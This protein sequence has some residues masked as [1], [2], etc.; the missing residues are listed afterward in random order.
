MNIDTIIENYDPSLKRYKDGN[1]IT[2]ELEIRKVMNKNNYDAWISKLNKISRKVNK[3]VKSEQHYKITYY[4]DNKT[5]KLTFKNGKIQYIRKTVKK[6]LNKNTKKYDYLSVNKFHAKLSLSNEELMK[7]LPTSAGEVKHTV[8]RKRITYQFPFYKIDLDCD[9]NSKYSCEIELKNIK[10]STV[11]IS[12]KTVKIILQHIIH[13]LA[14]PRPVAQK[15]VTLELGYIPFLQDHIVLPKKDGVT[16]FILVDR[17]GMYI[18]NQ[19]MN[20]YVYL[21]E[22]KEIDNKILL[23]YEHRVFI[24]EYIES[25]N[26]YYIFDTYQQ[27]TKNKS[28]SYKERLAIIKDFCKLSNLF[29]I[30]DYFMKGSLRER[31]VNG[32][33]YIN[34]NH[35]N[36]LDYDGLI[37]Q[38]IHESYNTKTI[39]KW[40]PSQLNT[41]DLLY[42]GG[43]LYSRNKTGLELVYDPQEKKHSTFI[44]SFTIINKKVLID[45]KIVEMHFNSKKRQ[46]IPM[47]IRHDK[48][49]PNFITVVN[50]LIKH[51]KNPI[52]QQNLLKSSNLVL[53]KQNK[54]SP[55]QILS[56][57]KI[58]QKYKYLHFNDDDIEKNYKEYNN[59]SETKI[60]YRLQPS[61]YDIINLNEDDCKRI[62]LFFKSTL[63]KTDIKEITIL[64]C[65]NNMYDIDVVINTKVRDFVNKLMNPEYT[66]LINIKVTLF[67]NENRGIYITKYLR[68]KYYLLDINNKKCDIKLWNPTLQLPTVDSLEQLRLFHR[69]IKKSVYSKFNLQNK[70]VLDIGIGRGVDLHILNRSNVKTLVGLDYDSKSL[71][72]A[73]VRF[74]NIKNKNIKQ[75]VTCKIDLT[76]DL[77][78]VIHKIQKCIQSN[79]MKFDY[80]VCNFAIQHFVPKLKEIITLVHDYLK[81]GG[82]FIGNYIDEKRVKKLLSDKKEYKSTIA[83]I[84]AINS[85]KYSFVLS[86]NEKS[87]YDMHRINTTFYNEYYFSKQDFIHYLKENDFRNIEIKD[88]SKY[89]GFDTLT[90]DQKIISRLYSTFITSKYNPPIQ[91]K[92]KR[93]PRKKT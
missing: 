73:N 78:E 59:L 55:K 70:S 51:I 71:A 81:P 37:F 2:Q 11:S 29:K 35:S 64:P 14:P 12:K 20:Q 91:V 68:K 39:F 40:K 24:S 80:V 32:L 92:L 49:Q 46:M 53:K 69:T 43:K 58:L 45:G 38:S 76:M 62:K 10:M 52:T 13:L 72:E 7:K 85:K 67:E 89:N 79:D 83:N 65:E 47:R 42:R 60:K 48:R 16:S 87:Y 1:I 54:E 6:K 19:Q 25:Q 84:K 9:N 56:N 88:F 61:K 82:K 93:K 44:N 23:K 31:I 33:E 30:T 28:T 8:E 17:F 34:I 15:P 21:S 66:K 22:S 5:R 77:K 63:S 57:S 4:S 90:P 36:P 27:F 26:K 74:E 86:S 18:W 75:F 3:N 50:N 41:I